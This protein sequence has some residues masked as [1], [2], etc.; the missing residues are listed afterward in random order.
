MASGEEAEWLPP[1]PEVSPSHAPVLPLPFMAAV[2]PLKDAVLLFMGVVVAWMET[3][4]VINGRSCGIPG[5]VAAVYGVNADG[6]GA[7]GG[8][9]GGRKGGRKGGGGRYQRVSCYG[10]AMRCPV[11][12]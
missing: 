3:N 4:A 8:G 11:L 2:L 5:C 7:G 10:C 1:H 6:Y 12:T 9:E